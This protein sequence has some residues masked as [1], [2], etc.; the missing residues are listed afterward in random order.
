MIYKQSVTSDS[1]VVTYSLFEAASGVREYHLMLE[2]TDYERSF[3]EQLEALHSAFAQYSAGELKEATPVFKR[4]FLSDVANQANLL[5]DAISEDTPCAVSVIQQA[6]LSGAKVSLWVCLQTQIVTGMIAEGL[7]EVTH[8]GY[9]HLWGVHD[10]TT[11]AGAAEQTSLLFRD[12]MKQ[13]EQSGCNLA[14][15]CLRT[16]LFVEHVDRNYLGVVNARNDIFDMQK[17]TA[18]THYIASTGIGG[19]SACPES[20]VR[21]DTY[22]VSGLRPEQIQY[23]YAPDHMNPTHEYGV[24]FERGTCVHY[25]DRRQVFISGTASIDNKG[26]IVFPGDIRK[27]TKRMWENVAALLTEA[28][29]S[30]DDLSQMIVYLRDPADYTI[31]RK[32]F[33]QK[34]PDVPQVIV[35]APVCRPGWLIEMECMALKACRQDAYYAY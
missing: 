15:H 12:Y 33:E 9:R 28:G 22:A 8:N 25:G 20:L 4:Y 13:L 24:S 16:W 18:D 3:Q 23:L 30:F 2:G 5:S 21:M 35:Y 31:V 32:L 19:R 6:P 11:A 14:D 17:L 27:Q 1:V 7:F 10:A 29:C 34:F 26:E